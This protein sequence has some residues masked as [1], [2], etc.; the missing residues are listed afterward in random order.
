M[1]LSLPIIWEIAGVAKAFRYRAS[2]VEYETRFWNF[3]AIYGG[4]V[5]VVTAVPLAAER[6]STEPLPDG[7][8]QPP[9]HSTMH[10]GKRDLRDDV[11]WAR[12][13]G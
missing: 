4:K 9:L 10:N 5:G 1:P 12:A 6:L 3:G 8:P 7:R 11:V 13:A 2:I